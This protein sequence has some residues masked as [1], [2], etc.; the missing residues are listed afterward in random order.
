MFKACNACDLFAIIPAGKKMEVGIKIMPRILCT[1]SEE[2]L[3]ELKNGAKER[4][5]SIS[6]YIRQIVHNNFKS[7]E[8]KDQKEKDKEVV[9]AIEALIPV[10]VEALAQTSSKVPSEERIKEVTTMLIQRWNAHI[11]KQEK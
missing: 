6:G 8:S 5:L 10:F 3:S 7:R 11:Q 4:G 9:F 2:L 1:L